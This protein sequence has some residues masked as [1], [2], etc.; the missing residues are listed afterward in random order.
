MGATIAVSALGFCLYFAAAVA[1]DL[2]QVASAL[3]RLHYRDLA[4]IFGLS[5]LNYALRFVRWQWFLTT[6]GRSA[7][8]L[9]YSVPRTFGVSRASLLTPIPLSI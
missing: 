2:G 7:K 8:I 9:M 1:G 5:L 6:M 3:A 4:L